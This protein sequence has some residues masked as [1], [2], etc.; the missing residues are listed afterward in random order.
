MTA[1][2]HHILYIEDDV[3]DQMAFKRMAKM[4]EDQFCYT[5]SSDIE[6][7]RELIESNDYSVVITDYH[8]G[9]NTAFEIIP[10]IEDAPVIL[11][12]GGGDESLAVQAMKMGAYDYLIKDDHYDYLKFLPITVN[13]AIEHHQAKVKLLET[14]KVY[15]LLVETANDI[16]YKV[17]V[18]G[19][20][21]YVN[22]VGER[23]TG[24]TKEEILGA[25]FSILVHDEHKESVS[26]FYKEHFRELKENSYLEFPVVKKDGTEIWVGQNVSTIYDPDFPKRIIG[27]QG[28]VRDIS[29]QKK[30][31]ER[32]ETQRLLLERQ[33]KEIKNVQKLLEYTNG[34]LVSTNQNLEKLVEERT[35]SLQ[36]ANEE[37]QSINE[38][39]DIFIYRASHDLKGPIARMQGLANLA[40]TE[41]KGETLIEY[42]QKL[43]RSAREMSQMLAK[44]QAVNEIKRHT[45]CF[46]SV[47]L[48][49][50]IHSILEYY[51]QDAQNK[52]IE[53]EMSQVPELNI[54]SDKYLLN[55][56]LTPIIEN[57]VAFHNSAEIE[58]KKI[59]LS[60]EQNTDKITMTVWDN[61]TGI[62]KDYL[63]KVYDIFFRGS[64]LSIGNGL[65]L[66]IAEKCA[67]KLGA[68]L[69]I[70]SEEGGFTS[71]KVVHSMG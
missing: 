20:C 52:H 43:K 44:L 63:S 8:L 59:K 25:H 15:K 29:E 4:H 42:I 19:Y 16:I 39:L 33:N 35:E 23:V 70:D 32:I 28:V 1:D 7:A 5:I 12:T 6:S 54:T 61:G 2:K 51:Q 10:L 37:L 50:M 45:P 30:R 21:T 60:V 64:E 24:Y 46:E 71:V 66:Y 17:D 11:V 55:F 22:E 68:E 69:E 18:E 13:N 48:N 41:A 27:F 14:Q 31:D 47:D 67:E 62:S 56:I 40:L 58:G 34:N 53:I 3:V 49:S 65:G 36:T 38:E 9:A 26:N 57:A